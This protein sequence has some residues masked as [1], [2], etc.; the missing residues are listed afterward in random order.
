MFDININLQTTLCYI[1][2]SQHLKLGHNDDAYDAMIINPDQ[3]GII[4]L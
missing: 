4:C 2:F 3:V 1:L